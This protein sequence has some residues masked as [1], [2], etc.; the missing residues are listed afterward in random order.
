[1]RLDEERRDELIMLASRTK[2]HAFV[3]SYKMQPLPNHRNNSH[4]SSK[5]F[6]RFASLIAE[7]TYKVEASMLEIY[8]ERIRDL[9]VPM[10]QQPR[11]GL[12]I[13][14]SPTTGAYVDNLKKIP[15]IAYHQIE[16][17]RAPRLACRT[18][19]LC[20]KSNSLAL[21]LRPSQRLMT[22]GTKNR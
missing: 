11:G 10:S 7:T 13:R 16:V 3:P 18:R 12:K 8:N 22:F 21:S 5:P 19:S 6:S 17:R 2:S 4:P 1:M 20:M 15:V 9:F 14:D